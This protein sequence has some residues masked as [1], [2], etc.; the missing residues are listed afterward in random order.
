MSMTGTRCQLRT[1]VQS[2]SGYLS[3]GVIT[4][5]TSEISSCLASPRSRAWFR[6]RVRRTTRHG[7]GEPLTRLRQHRAAGTP[8]P[9]V[10]RLGAVS[11]THLRAHETGRNLVCRLLLEK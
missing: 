10:P 1:S 11:Y 2:S 7:T 5:S 9:E 3:F 8:A 6:R 4:L